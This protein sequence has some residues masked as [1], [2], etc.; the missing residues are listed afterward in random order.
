MT[1]PISQCYGK[2]QD[3][4]LGIPKVQVQAI[5]RVKT[6]I[7]MRSAVNLN[8]NSPYTVHI[9]TSY[10]CTKSTDTIYLFYLFVPFVSPQEVKYSVYI[11]SPESMV[12]FSLISGSDERLDFCNLVSLEYVN[13]T[14]SL[15]PFP[16]AV[17]QV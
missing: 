1:V 16:F 3:Q 12:F 15:L 9:H 13:N 10:T 14:P 17:M 4:L 2:S 6:L 11:M 8:E 7:Q 5:R